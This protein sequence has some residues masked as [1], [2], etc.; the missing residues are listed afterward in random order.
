METNKN[1]KK[2]CKKNWSKKLGESRSDPSLG[3][4]SSQDDDLAS[5]NIKK[6]INDQVIENS[7]KKISIFD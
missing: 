2:I 7:L 4:Y 1:T 5:L 6:Y 3:T